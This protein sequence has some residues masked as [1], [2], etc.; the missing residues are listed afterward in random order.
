MS[1]HDITVFQVMF[2]T[3]FHAFLRIGEMKATR[4]NLNL[5]L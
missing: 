1:Q 3:A 2:S 5:N 4:S